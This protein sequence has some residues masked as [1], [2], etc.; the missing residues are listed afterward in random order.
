MTIN[1]KEAGESETKEEITN[2]WELN[3]RNTLSEPQFAAPSVLS[4]DNPLSQD[5]RSL[6]VTM[7]KSKQIVGLQ[8]ASQNAV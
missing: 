3:S 6:V 4:S 2:H 7:G 8:P 1:L 5:P